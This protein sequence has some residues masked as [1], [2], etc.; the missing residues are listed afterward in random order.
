MKREVA[1][2]LATTR[3]I[4]PDAKLRADVLDGIVRGE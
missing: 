1:F 4:P 3:S 2:L